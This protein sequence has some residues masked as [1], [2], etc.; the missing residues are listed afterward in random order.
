MI[1]MSDV[2]LTHM[3][4]KGQ[5]VIPVE[6]RKEINAKE[7]TVFV[8]LGSGDTILLKKI[9]MPTKEKLKKEWSKLVEEGGKKAK[10]LGIE[11]ADVTKIVHKKRGVKHA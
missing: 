11:E 9:Q 3:T 4:S 7:G 10:K 1:I 8:V 5:V 2:E 6:I